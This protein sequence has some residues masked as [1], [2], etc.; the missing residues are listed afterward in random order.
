MK[1]QIVESR[2]YAGIFEG[3]RFSKTYI[4]TSSGYG[5]DSEVTDSGLEV[6][7]TIVDKSKGKTL[8]T[9]FRVMDTG[10]YSAPKDI[11]G[12]LFPEEKLVVPERREVLIDYLLKG[13]I[14]QMEESEGELPR[15]MPVPQSI[16][17]AEESVRQALNTRIYHVAV[18][19]PD[20]GDLIRRG[21]LYNESGR[22]ETLFPIT[23]EDIPES[24]E[25]EDIPPLAVL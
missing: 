18:S 13:M 15:N 17:D 14:D 2:N 3:E 8:K 9:N 25:P 1:E 23:T 20:N 19:R 12:L 10:I 21:F 22:V 16:S 24:K 7:V 11:E 5:G 4:R 6:S